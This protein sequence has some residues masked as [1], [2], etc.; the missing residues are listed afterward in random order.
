MVPPLGVLLSAKD[1]TDALFA[2]F[3]HDTTLDL[4]WFAVDGVR[5]EL[6]LSNRERSAIGQ[7][8]FAGDW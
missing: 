1:H 8:R 4:H 3:H 2:E 7:N 5:F 6:P